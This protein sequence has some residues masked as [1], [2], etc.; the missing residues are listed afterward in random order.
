MPVATPG[1]LEVRPGDDQAIDRVEEWFRAYQATRNPAIR[2]QIILAHLGLADRLAAR[3]RRSRGVCYEDLVQ[4]ARVGLVSA[5]NGYD[6]SRPNPFIAYAIVCI[7]GELR[8]FL[9]DTSW[10]LHVGRLDKERAL[11]VLDARDML[12][13]TLG[14]SPTEAEVATYLGV[15]EGWV[16]EA[17]EAV[18]AR[19]AFSLDQPIDQD[20]GPTIGSLVS[21]P[22]SDTEIEDRLVLPEL[23]AS[24]PDVER[25]AVTL[26]FFD[27]LKQ[28]EIGAMLGYS[29]MHV[30]RLLR[31]ALT[32]MRQQ[33][34]S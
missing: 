28:R 14:R 20:S 22:V 32:R 26:R 18:S 29:Q 30:S 21:A 15:C 24:L 31:R 19:S 25:R 34:W 27:D 33:L 10:C 23:I 6:P 13:V 11:Q 2:E 7:T 5:V 17:L 8:R 1:Q 3:L 9:R 4:V 16:V 12:T